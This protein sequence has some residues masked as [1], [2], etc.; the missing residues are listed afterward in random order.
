[1]RGTRESKLWNE[2]VARY[3][4][5]GYKTLVGAQ[6]R[7]AVHDR[8]GWPLAMLGFSTAAW[9]LA[10]RDNFIGW[11]RQLREKNLPFVVDNPRFLILPWINIPNLG[12]AHPG[13]HPPAPAR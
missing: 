4:Y 3:H 6:M 11:T 13:H 9:K 8:D 10:P 12:F 5:L 1:M 2:F 7:Y